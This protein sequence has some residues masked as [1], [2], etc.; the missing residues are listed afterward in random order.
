MVARPLS[1]IVCWMICFH[2]VMTG[3]DAMVHAILLAI[4]F[5][6]APVSVPARLG[7]A[8]PYRRALYAA[9]A[10]LYAGWSSGWPGTPPQV[11]RPGAGAGR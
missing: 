2:T 3:N 10:L 4:A 6:H 1:L 5:A 11:G 7:V 8:L 9:L